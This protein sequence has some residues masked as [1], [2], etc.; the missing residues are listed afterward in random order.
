MTAKEKAQELIMTF[1]DITIES[2]PKEWTINRIPIPLRKTF[3]VLCVDEILNAIPKMVGGRVLYNN[4]AIE[5]W[6][7]VKNQINKI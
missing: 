2:A 1:G 3:A 4:P 5:F 6:N 7:E